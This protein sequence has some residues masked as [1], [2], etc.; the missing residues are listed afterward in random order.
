MYASKGNLGIDDVTNPVSSEHINDE[1]LGK[2]QKEWYP[3][4]EMDKVDEFTVDNVTNEF[5]P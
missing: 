3:G 4:A 1:F 5:D 2:A